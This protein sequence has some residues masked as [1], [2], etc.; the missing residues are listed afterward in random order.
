MPI[1][2]CSVVFF[3]TSN[4]PGILDVKLA[5]VVFPISISPKK[6]FK[7]SFPLHESVRIPV[8]GF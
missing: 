6:T 5:T 7:V 1:V 4:N 8:F 2:F 3:G